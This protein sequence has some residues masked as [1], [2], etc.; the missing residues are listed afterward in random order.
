MCVDWAPLPHARLN[1][2]G[3]VH[4]ARARGVARGMWV[5]A[6]GGWVG[7]GTAHTPINPDAR[8]THTQS[9]LQA[10]EALT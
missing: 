6:E 8:H 7:M 10:V 3:I 4:V 9:S 5:H 1:Q 2:G